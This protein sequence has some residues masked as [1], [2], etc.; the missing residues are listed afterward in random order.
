MTDSPTFNN[1]VAILVNSTV[2]KV[3][4]FDDETYAAIKS[5]PVFLD[6]KG[7][8]DIPELGHVYN[9]TTRTFSAPDPT[10][11]EPLNITIE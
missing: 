1:P 6:L 2:V 8:T 11:P 7:G 4:N 9:P 10:A 5:N 3:I